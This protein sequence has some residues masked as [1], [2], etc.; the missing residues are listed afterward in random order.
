MRLRPYHSGLGIKGVVWITLMLAEGAF[1][2]DR[3]AVPARAKPDDYAAHVN[4]Q[5]RTYAA[6]VLSK[7]QVKHLFAFDIS[8]YYTVLEVACYP[9]E[10]AAVKLDPDSFVVKAGKEK[11][12][13]RPADAMTVAA[14]IQQKNTPRPPSETTPVYTQAQIGYETG[15]DPYTGRR[16]HD[17]YGGAGV[18]VG[19]PPEPQFPSPGGWPQD[20]EL[21]EHQLAEHSLPGGRFTH[22]V[23][24][25]LYFPSALLKKAKG[26]YE[27]KDLDDPSGVELDVPTKSH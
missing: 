1:A 22:P 25:Y 3:P 26:S 13:V 20:R 27:L 10:G 14:S 24:G 5:Q 17:V 9:G 6:S 2:Q 21:L 23:A 8:K 19:G 7:D 15:T 16:I 12:V 18:A 11:D 4:L